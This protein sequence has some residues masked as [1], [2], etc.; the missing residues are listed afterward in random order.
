MNV[1]RILKPS[2]IISIVL[3]LLVV[4]YVRPLTL[5]FA[6]KRRAR[7]A[8][9]L[10][11][12]PKPLT[13]VSIERS[14]GRKFSYF[15][16][17]FEVPWTEVKQEK[18]LRSMDIV[19][20]SNGTVVI[21][22]DPAQSVDKL[23]VLTQKGTKNEAAVRNIFP[24]EATRSNYA[25]CS[26]ILYLTPSD[27]RLFSSRREMVSNSVLLMLKP[28]WAHAKKGGLYSFHTEWLRGFQEGDPTHDKNVV[29]DAF[30]AQDHEI[31]LSI[32]SGQSAKHNFTQSDV[33]RIL[34][35]LRP[36]TPD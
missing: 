2:T 33:N 14:A 35:S 24:D 31:E 10:W 36:V 32:G 15:G 20:F 28:A 25:L 29:I 11:I 6:V 12:V 4:V 19:Y 26:T 7:T 23:K 5:L 21:L 18:N 34:F 22:F 13:D 27:L 17:Q 16:Y 9:E 1:R 3:I 8:P 30:D